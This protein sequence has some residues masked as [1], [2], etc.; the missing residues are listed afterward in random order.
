MFGV[1]FLKELD[2]A[3]ESGAGASDRVEIGRNPR[4]FAQSGAGWIG[5]IDDLFGE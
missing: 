2:G 4:A 3:L 1:F 5:E